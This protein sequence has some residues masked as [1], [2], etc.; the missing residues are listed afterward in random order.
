MDIIN[1]GTTTTIIDNKKVNEITWDAHYDGKI[2]D[3]NLDLSNPGQK[4]HISMKL[5][6]EDIMRLLD[7]P[8]INQS[9]DERLIKDFSLQSNINK[10]KN[11]NKNRMLLKKAN[12]ATKT[13]SKKS[14]KTLKGSGKAKRNVTN[15]SRK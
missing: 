1:T 5:T 9:L 2:A 11:K 15:K 8:T 13:K 7:K 10:N 14:K 3:I 12:L 6:N 4:E